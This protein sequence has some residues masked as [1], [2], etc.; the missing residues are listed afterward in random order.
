[1]VLI[2]GAGHGLSEGVAQAVAEA[3]AAVACADLDVPAARQ[4][5]EQ[6]RRLEG[7]AIAV[8]IKVAEEASVR[9]M[10]EAMVDQLGELDVIFCNAIISGGS[11]GR[12]HDLPLDGWHRVLAVNLTGVFLCAREAARVMLARG[13]RGKLILTASIYGQVG[14][15]NGRSPAYTAAKGD[16][17]NLTREL[18]RRTPG[19]ASR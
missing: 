15:Y 11:S 4:T 16:M 8:D 5:A 3:G 1:V 6:I 9:H 13:R 17:V 12:A 14:S 19:T 2:M 10:V 18:A 7:I